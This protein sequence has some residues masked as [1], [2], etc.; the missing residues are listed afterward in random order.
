MATASFDKTFV[1]SNKTSI[2]KIRQDLAH[3]RQIE[4]QV[5][6]YKAENAKGIELLRQRLS[7]SAA[8]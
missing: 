5:R 2:D 4:V 7:N 8:S 1:V 3:P 6:D